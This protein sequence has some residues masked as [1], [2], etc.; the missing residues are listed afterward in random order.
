MKNVK[1]TMALIFC[2][3]ILL[4][5]NPLMAQ[6]GQGNGQGNREEMKKR[7]E[8]LKVKLK[9][10][11]EQSAMYDKIISSNREEA[12]T[13][14]MALPED[15]SRLEK[16]E[17]MKKSMEKADGEIL[18]ILDGEQQKIYKEE[19]EKMKAEMKA[20]RDQKKGKGKK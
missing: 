14:M 5:F 15:A 13:Q 6:T 11:P 4:I 19:K 2:L 8:E 3:G 12:R 1:K 16:S 20:K 17:I 18:E 9:L 7:S 10:S